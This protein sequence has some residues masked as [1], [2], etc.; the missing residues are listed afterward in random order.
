MAG[1]SLYYPHVSFFRDL[2]PP[3][4][5]PFL[6][7]TIGLALSTDPRGGTDPVPGLEYPVSGKALEPFVPYPPLSCRPS[8][9]TFA[10]INGFKIIQ[11]IGVSQ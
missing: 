5:A 7:Q 2:F 10:F 4:T 3:G 9:K 6:G 11:G 8:F 1:F